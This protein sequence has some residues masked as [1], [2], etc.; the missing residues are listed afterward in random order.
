MTTPP[1]PANFMNSRLL[2]PL[3]S[4]VASLREVNGPPWA[5]AKALP[6]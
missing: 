3:R 5:S 4:I 6:F 1:S 2:N